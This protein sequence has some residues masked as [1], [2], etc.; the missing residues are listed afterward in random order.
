MCDIKLD[1][2][3]LIMR[4]LLKAAVPA[5][6]LVQI[7][8]VPTLGADSHFSKSLSRLDP[9]TRLEQVCDIEAMERI[10][11]GNNPFHPD[12][13]KS[14]VITSPQHIGNTLKGFG[15]AFR[16]NGHWYSFSFTCEGSPD[17]MKVL[18]FS[19]QIGKLIPESKWSAYGLWR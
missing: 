10:D 2:D 19:Y 1:G 16:S 4:Y 14:N 18:S 9:E 15:G 11:Q 5:F 6:V 7:Y 8:A 12:R 13:A 3:G 17:H